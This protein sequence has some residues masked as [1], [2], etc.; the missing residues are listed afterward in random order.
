MSILLLIVILIFA[1]G[2]AYVINMAGLPQPI[3]W[4]LYAI[5]ILILLGV[6]LNLA[7]VNVL[8]ARV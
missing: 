7:G 4:L 6:L 3:T 2:V 1:I 8:G 5:I